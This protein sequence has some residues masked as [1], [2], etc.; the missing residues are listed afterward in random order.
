ML[1]TTGRCLEAR[2]VLY[3]HAVWVSHWFQAE[4]LYVKFESPTHQPGSPQI[5]PEPGSQGRG[6]RR[7][8]LLV[9]SWSS[10]HP[11]GRS[12]STS[13]LN[14]AT[15]FWRPGLVVGTLIQVCSSE[16][17]AGHKF[18]RASQTIPFVSGPTWGPKPKSLWQNPNLGRHQ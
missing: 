3:C 13:N 8:P 17:G 6:K 1:G 16:N 9:M 4:P 2:S 12:L 11:V 10:K 14:F 5:S 18:F 15:K 7:M